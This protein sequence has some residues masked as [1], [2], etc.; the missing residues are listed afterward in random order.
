MFSG[1]VQQLAHT[2]PGLMAV[3]A[4]AA[5]IGLFVG[6]KS[7]RRF[8]LIEDV[9]T[10]RVRSAHQGY[11]ELIGRAVMLEGEPIVAPLSHLQCCWFTYRIEERGDKHWDTLESGT[12]DGLFV[13]RDETGDCVIDPDGAEV[14][15]THNK[16]WTDGRYRYHETRLMDGDPL[17]A[18]GWFRSHGDG[19][20]GDALAQVTAEIL[21]RWKQRPDTLRERFDHDRNGTIDLEEWEDAR[22]V[23]RR[24]AEAELR[25]REPV[26]VRH[27]LSKPANGV[28]LLAN[29]EQNSLVRRHKWRAAIG[30]TVFF[31]GGGFATLMLSARLMG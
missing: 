22:A 27:L 18:I 25:E 30:L 4:V 21:R 10:A 3:A 16:T 12:S 15:S 17:Y 8:R 5:L 26:P 24:E 11:V 7:L 13:L 29:R 2:H 9:P 28:F 31:L 14:D 6:F 1:T 20:T 19:D 23:A